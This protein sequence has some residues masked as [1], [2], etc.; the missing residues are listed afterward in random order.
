LRVSSHDG[1]GDLSR[2][3]AARRALRAAVFL[4]SL[5]ASCNGNPATNPIPPITSPPSGAIPGPSTGPTRIALV[6]A[7][8]VP[9][10]TLAGCGNGA[11]GCTGRIRMAFRLTPTATGSVLWCVGFL[12]AA[13]KTA[14]LQG[15]TGGLQLRAGEAQ[16]VEVVFDLPA[17][18]DRCRTPLEITDLALTVEG[19]IEVASRQEWGLRYRLVP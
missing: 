4:T 16:T 19:T 12:H 15:R 10:A 6:S 13:D 8:P 18:G 14:C 9:A 5:I 1:G 7:D 17:A 11:S 2:W 3:G